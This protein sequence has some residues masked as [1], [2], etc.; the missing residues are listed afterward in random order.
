MVWNGY[1]TFVAITNLNAKL[2]E[3]Q[4]IAASITATIIPQIQI[5]MS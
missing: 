3:W 5:Y 2:K 4:T 1:T